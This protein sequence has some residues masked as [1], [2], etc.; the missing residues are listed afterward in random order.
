VKPSSRDIIIFIE[1][2]IFVA[3]FVSEINGSLLRFFDEDTFYVTTTIT[4]VTEEIFK[5]LPILLYAFGISD[6]R[7]KLITISF[8]LGIGF[9]LFENSYILIANID[10][11][12][13]GWS[14][15][16]GFSTGL[17]HGI[18]TAMVGF[19]MS[20][21]K[22]KRKLFVVG[23]IALLMTAITYHASFN[24]M[25]QYDRMNWYG[26]AMPMITYIPFMIY[27]IRAEIKERKMA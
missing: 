7:D 3:L 11:V 2:G 25:V 16:R 22:K 23:T 8:A 12:T 26:F 1:T 15:V 10:N 20:F 5:A 17:M 4:P 21:V 18:C 19:G 27:R 13:L 24:L 14:A 6:N 9:A